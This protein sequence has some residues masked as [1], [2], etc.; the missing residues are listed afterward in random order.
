MRIDIRSGAISLAI[1]TALTASWL[2]SADATAGVAIRSNVEVT[3]AT[4]EQLEL[5]AWAVGRFEAAGLEPPSLEI[6]FHR[7]SSGCG[8]HLG[9]AR[10][11]K[12]D[13]CTTLL[14]AMTRRVLL[15][16]MS[17]IW[18]DQDVSPSD[19]GAFLAS[20]GLRT[21]NGSSEPWS[22]RGYEQGAEILSW[23]LGERILTPQIPKNGPEEIALAYELLTGRPY[24]ATPLDATADAD[25]ALRGSNEGMNQ[26]ASGEEVLGML[27]A[28]IPPVLPSGGPS[29][30]DGPALIAMIV[31]FAV[32]ALGLAIRRAR[33]HRRVIEQDI[34][35]SYDRAA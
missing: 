15:H 25:P 19:R 23:T 22:E 8:G 30:G 21:W 27:G 16:E 31:S 20:R 24:A 9:L 14:N 13:V 5:A 35:R 3:N 17:H 4:P 10:L 34:E 2:R 32:L 29:S 1:V 26:R 33:S 28:P 11:A 6:A 12:V 18:L 7:G